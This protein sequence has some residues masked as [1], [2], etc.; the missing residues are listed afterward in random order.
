VLTPFQKRKL[1]RK[2]HLFDHR[3]TGRIGWRDIERVLEN[4]LEVSGWSM[5]REERAELMRQGFTGWQLLAAAADTN[6]DG[7]IDLEEWYTFYAEHIYGRDNEPGTLPSWLVRLEDLSFSAMDQ[8][9]DDRISQA[10]YSALLAAYGIREDLDT[11]FAKIDSDGDGYISRA[12]WHTLHERYYAGRE[13]LGEEAD[14][15]WGD[16]YKAFFK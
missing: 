4:V 16:V 15:L 5:D 2:F 11:A 13:P 10:E 14:W 1:A 7:E 3:Q 12:E 8:N 6:E 9:G